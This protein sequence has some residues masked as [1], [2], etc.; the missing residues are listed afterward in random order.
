MLKQMRTFLSWIE[1]LAH[2]KIVG[3]TVIADNVTYI[4]GVSLKQ[5]FWNSA[6]S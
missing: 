3:K 2:K 5:G 6:A 4:S 1:H